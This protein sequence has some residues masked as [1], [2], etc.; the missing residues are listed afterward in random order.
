MRQ[1]TETLNL[2]EKENIIDEASH[3]QVICNLLP[4]EKGIEGINLG[5]KVDK[6]L[7]KKYNKQSNK[8]R[9]VV[10]VRQLNS[11]LPTTSV[12]NIPKINE[13]LS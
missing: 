9:A 11:L 8:K 6:Y 13:S 3:P 12:I 1:V 4:M 7:N 10:D 5:S 2:L